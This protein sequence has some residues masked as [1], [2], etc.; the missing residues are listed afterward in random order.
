[1]LGRMA[2]MKQR[3]TAAVFSGMRLRAVMDGIRR[4]HEA[5]EVKLSPAF[6][7]AFEQLAAI[8][9]MRD[10]LVHWGIESDGA[11]LVASNMLRAHADRTKREVHVSSATL[12]GMTRD[13]VDIQK[14]LLLYVLNTNGSADPIRDRSRVDTSVGR[15]PWRFRSA[16]L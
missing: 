2:G 9:T 1:M 12:V 5:K 10:R 3:E 13:V 6:V 14:M 15:R 7:E 8:N 11:Q 4:L 16:S